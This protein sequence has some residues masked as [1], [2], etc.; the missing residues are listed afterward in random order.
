MTIVAIWL[1]PSDDAL[2]A[3]ADTRISAPGEAGGAIIRTDSGAKLFALPIS[4]F[5]IGSEPSYRRHRHYSTSVGFAFAGDVL[6]ATMTYATASTFLQNLGTVE[7]ADPPLLSDVAKLVRTVAI[8]FSKESLASSNGKYGEFEAS[9]F[10]WEAHLN[11]FVVYHLTPKISSE[12]FSIDIHEHFPNDNR[13]VLMMGSGRS[14]LSSKIDTIRQNGKDEFGRSGRIPKL[15]VEGIVREDVG[16]VGG[17][18]SISIATQWGYELYSWVRPIEIGK[19][20][21]TIAFNGID[22]HG[23]PRQV[24]HYLVVMPGMV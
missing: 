12:S 23:E 13:T 19:P 6:P 14:R 5:R 15:A 7:T 22:L 9:L 1:E 4:C 11:R 24:G 10:G 16:D 18:L 8:G 2:W 20:D 21:A 17:S 3:V